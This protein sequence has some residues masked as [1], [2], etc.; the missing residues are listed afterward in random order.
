MLAAQNERF[1]KP[2]ALRGA[3]LKASQERKISVNNQIFTHECSSPEACNLQLARGASTGAC[4]NRRTVDR[5][6]SCPLPRWAS[7]IP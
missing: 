3:D 1:L 5:P 2:S 6:S 4:A 7:P